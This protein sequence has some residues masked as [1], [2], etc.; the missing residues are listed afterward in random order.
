MYVEGEFLIHVGALRTVGHI[1]K[2]FKAKQINSRQCIVG[3]TRS[4]ISK[5]WIA[6]CSIR[7]HINKAWSRPWS[8]DVL[9]ISI[10]LVLKTVQMDT[11]NA[12][13]FFLS[14]HR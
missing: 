4:G 12:A 5:P 8:L 14:A 9:E 1:L 3:S 13:S 11:L 6:H 2:T 7:V 10:T